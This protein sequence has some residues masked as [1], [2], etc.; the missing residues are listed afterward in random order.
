[1][2]NG[3]RRFIENGASEEVAL[4]AAQAFAVLAFTVVVVVDAAKESVVV[5]IIEIPST[6]M[7]P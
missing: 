4:C 6:S 3:S 2:G 1:L 5:D 7:R